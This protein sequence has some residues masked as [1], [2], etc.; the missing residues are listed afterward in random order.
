VTADRTSLYRTM[1]AIRAFETAAARLLRAGKLGGGVHLSI[2]QE[3][4]A[5]GVCSALA[6][7]D[8]ITTTHRGHGH[9]LAKGGDPERMFAELLGRLD[10]YC[11]GKAG[12]M[13][14]ADPGKGILGATAIVGGGLPMA[15]GA[16]LSAQVRRSGQVAVAFFGE[17]AVAEGIFHES[18]NLASLWRLPVVLVCENNQYAELTPV[19]VHLA[20]D[21]HR[22]AEPFGIS[23]VH[24]D[25]ND[26][27]AVHE[28]TFE[29]ASRARRGEGPTLLECET[30]RWSGH[31]E[32]DPEKYRTR[33]EVEGWKAR[34]PIARLR[35][36][37]APAVGAQEFAE[38]DAEVEREIQ[39]AVDRAL[40]GTETPAAAL[41]DD[42][43]TGSPGR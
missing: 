20:A 4:V 12:S 14:I 23:G 29:A 9:C 13:H 37:L 19:G 18:L 3:A 10:G 31:Y 17:G 30:Y 5:A 25:G 36:R 11:K 15:V 22:L 24:V 35:E 39:S 33:E 41:L 42:V 27:E 16:A 43:Y 32:G 7:D 21:V 26:V 8:L 28:A 6:P 2:G 40:A 34:D 1:V 38:I